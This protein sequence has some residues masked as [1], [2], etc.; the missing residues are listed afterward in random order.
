MGRLRALPFA[1]RVAVVLGL[2]ALSVGIVLA[3]PPLPQDP[4]HHDFADGRALLGIPNF[5]NVVTNL[6]FYL[7][8]AL[9][10]F[11]LARGG[12]P[13]GRGER[14][15]CV[16]LF[17]GCLLTGFG[18]TC[19]HWTPGDETLVWDRMPLAL[20][21]MSVLALVVAERISPRWGTALLGPLLALGAG[22]V[23]YWREA[24][25]LRLYALVQFF[26][27]AAIPAI[28]ILFPPRFTRSPELLSAAGLYALAKMA[29]VLDAPL[30]RLTGALSGHTLKHVLAAAAA[31]CLLGLVAPRP[32]GLS[33]AGGRG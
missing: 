31:A 16:A 9:G 3:L 32:F 21:F 20:A 10:L 30:F 7:V 5:A 26:P 28:V 33:R 11:L 19:Y 23:L 18:S 1:T 4:R 6:G 12:G 17:A 15:A 14:W 8:G 2:S 22:S 25:D 24:G 29:E 27:L 13:E